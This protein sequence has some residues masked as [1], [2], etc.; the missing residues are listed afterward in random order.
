MKT[1]GP[2]PDF[3]AEWAFCD[4]CSRRT[5]SRNRY[6]SEEPERCSMCGRLRSDAPL[7]DR[8]QEERQRQAQRVSEARFRQLGLLLGSGKG[9]R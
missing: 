6:R 1:S 5:V 9:S 8:V 2:M 7:R 3:Q 4:H